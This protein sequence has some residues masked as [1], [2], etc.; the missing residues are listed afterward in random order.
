MGEQRPGVPVPRAG[1]PTDRPGR[2]AAQGARPGAGRG[3]HRRVRAHHGRPPPG[4]RLADRPVGGRVRRDRDDD[5]RQP[6]AVRRRRGPVPLPPRPGRRP[7]AAARRGRRA[8][9]PR[10]RGDVPGAAGDHPGPSPACPTA[11]RAPPSGAL[12]RAW[13]PSSARLFDL[14]GP[15]RAYFGEKDFQQLVVVRRMS[16]RPGTPRR[17]SSG[18]DRARRRRPR[19][20][21]PQPVPDARRAGRGTGAAPRPTGCSRRD[22]RWAV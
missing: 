4:A 20:V 19:P 6:A 1:D 15:S 22:R 7:A 5:L 8:S 10:R 12:R 9:S 18:A 3:P 17:R 16:R 21:E 13:P 11:S 2:R 14:P